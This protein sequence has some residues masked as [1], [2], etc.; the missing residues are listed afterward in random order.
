MTVEHTVTT[1]AS[2]NGLL[3]LALESLPSIDGQELTSDQALMLFDVV[4]LVKRSVK[5]LSDEVSKTILP[6]HLRW[7]AR[8]IWRG[9]S[10]KGLKLGKKKS[11]D[12]RDD[13]RCV[14]ALLNHY[15]GDFSFISRGEYG[16]LGSD[17]WKVGAIR[18]LG[19]DEHLVMT[20]S[21]TV[22]I[23]ELDSNFTKG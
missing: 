21:E 14:E 22:S 20:E 1:I 9:E 2:A 3:K 10:G 4:T 7:V 6:D 8:P 18:K 17:P 13:K 12:V 16:V 19:L 11:Y 23:I 15:G 5:T